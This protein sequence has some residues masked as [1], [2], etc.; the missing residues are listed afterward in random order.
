MMKLLLIDDHKLYLEG[1]RAVLE[2]LLPECQIFTSDN[3]QDAIEI[4]KSEKDIEIILL[5]LRMPMGG[6]PAFM[7]GMKEISLAIP[8]LIVSASENSADVKMAISLGVSGYLPKSATGTDL[9]LAIETILQGDEYLPDGWLEFLMNSKNVSVNDGDIK[10]SLSPRLFDILQLIEK[11]FTTSEIGHL[12]ELSEHTVKS[13]V[14]DL[15]SRFDVHSR[16]ELVQTARQ[17]HFFSMRG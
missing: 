9:L 10:I 1:V 11:G 8:V 3:I 6:A 16:T 4:I 5:D 15:F 17:L 2:Q 13:Y 14:K 7:N 12:L